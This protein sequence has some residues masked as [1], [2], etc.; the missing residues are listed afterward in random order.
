MLN[1]SRLSAWFK[2]HWILLLALTLG[3]V[4]R[5]GIGLDW[6]EHS[7]LHPDERFLSMVAEPLRLPSSISEY[8]DSDTSPLS[9]HNKGNVYYV[10]GTLPLFLLRATGDFLFWIGKESWKFT[11]Y[12]GNLYLGRVLASLIDI[13]AAIVVFLLGKRLYSPL[14]G[15]VAAV[16]FSF[17]VQNIQLS[18]FFGMENFVGFFVAWSALLL[19]QKQIWKKELL[20]GFVLGMGM[21]SKVSA[22]FFIPIAG[23]FFLYPSV[24]PKSYGLPIRF[25]FSKFFTGILAFILFCLFAYLGFRIFQPYAFQSF[26]WF[27]LSP[28][29]LE[30]MRKI[31]ELTDGGEWPPN[32]QWAGRTPVL[33]T[34][35]QLIKWE[36][37]PF[38]GIPA[39]AG[40]LYGA[41]ALC[42]KRDIRHL[43]PVLF[44]LTFLLYQ[45]TRFVKYGRYLSIIYPFLAVLAGYFLIEVASKYFKR[46]PLVCCVGTFL[47]AAAFTNIYS[48]DNTRVRASR[49]IFANAPQ[50]SVIANESWDDGMPLRV[51][52]KDG[53]GG[54]Y[55]EVQLNHFETDTPRKLEETLSKINQADYIILSSN[56]AYGTIPRLPKRYPFTTYYYKMLLSGELGFDLVHVSATYPNLFGFSINTDTAVES[57]TVYDHPKV[58]VFKKGPRFNL[59]YARERLSNFPPGFFEPLVKVKTVEA[60]WVYSLPR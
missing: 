16:L 43:I 48:V 51:D 24:T 20:A 33:F 13:F 38:F 1:M 53:F 34:L 36:M 12:G 49:W 9:P 41:W 4:F 8:F 42:R 15:L 35:S 23:I 10:Y 30:N 44:C 52:G 56:R 50:G 58:L 21:A 3:L 22:V 37:G 18:H 55:K 14:V 27:K 7:Q 40:L 57:F 5:C 46:A 17:S 32:V 39:I 60:P 19:L 11:E 25:S 54:I 6:D 29:F 47:W 26:S 31:K 59:E 28:I 2:S 45:S